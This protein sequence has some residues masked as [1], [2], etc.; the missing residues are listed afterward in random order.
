MRWL[1]IARKDVA[2]ARR[3]RNV[4]VVLGLFVLIGVGMGYLYGDSDPSG[5]GAGLAGAMYLVL[6]ALVSLVALLLAQNAVV[7]KAESGELTALLGLPFSRAEVI[8]GTF[9]GRA[10]VVAASTVAGMGIAPLVAVA[11]GAPVWF[12]GYLLTTLVV[13]LGGVAF[14]GVA[15]GLSAAT[16]S[17][18]RAAAG[19]FGLFLLFFVRI[20]NFLPT[21]VV[22]VVNG[23]SMPRTQPGWVDW[24]V[25]LNPLY[26]MQN[27]LH[28]LSPRLE[29]VALYGPV[30][31]GA[32]A[33][34]AAWFGLVVVAFWAVVPTLLG[35]WRFDR[36][37]L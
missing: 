7:E 2:D 36:R 30:R 4:W 28:G 19:A 35:Y 11:F 14:V 16:R 29:S 17:S 22:Y 32:P 20:W 25:E 23:F 27:L 12:G 8:W 3:N 34:D 6:S 5:E 18:T 24:V 1:Q 26:A 10:A 31:Q 15:L 13:V 33:H 37:D 9:A 21:A